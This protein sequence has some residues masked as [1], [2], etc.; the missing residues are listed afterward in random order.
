MTEQRYKN[1][2]CVVLIFA[3]SYLVSGQVL[4]NVSAQARFDSGWSLVNSEGDIT[5]TKDGRRTV[6]QSGSSKPQG[7]L[8]GVKDMVQT[9]KGTAELRLLSGNSEAEM[10]IKLSGNTSVVVNEFLNEVSLDLLYG[11][12]KIQSSFPVTVKTGNFSS[13][14]RSCDAE[15]EYASKPGYPQPVLTI[16]CY[17]GEGELLV[18]PA[19]E[20]EGAR[21]NI[22]NAEKLSLDYRMPFFY[23]ERK[24]LDSQ[25][26]ETRATVLEDNENSPFYIYST[27]SATGSGVSLSENSGEPNFSLDAAAKNKITKLKIGKA[28]TGILFISAGAAMQ[29]YAFFA[30]PGDEKKNLLLYGAYGPFTLGAAFLFDAAVNNKAPARTAN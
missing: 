14:F 30:N 2:F 23:L 4:E 5:I 18:N 11:R 28:I 8:L 22:R 15:M 19:L 27:D 21:F 7:I 10:S 24:S 3:S 29:G 16:N 9:G 1:M 20:T 12:V 13:F 17:K 25:S 6:Y 26:G